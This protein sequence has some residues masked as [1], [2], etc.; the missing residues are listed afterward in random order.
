MSIRTLYRA[1]YSRHILRAHLQGFT[2]MPF[3][4]FLALCLSV[5]A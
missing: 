1:A 2:P 4:A 5:E 3:C